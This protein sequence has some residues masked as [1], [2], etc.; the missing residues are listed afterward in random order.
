[1]SQET[2]ELVQESL[3]VFEK[4]DNDLA[5]VVA[6]EEARWPRWSETTSEHDH[7]D[8]YVEDAAKNVLGEWKEVTGLLKVSFRL[9]ISAPF[10]GR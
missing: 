9:T 8:V 10:G 1:M 7:C 2:R 6:R 5:W 3:A 4:F